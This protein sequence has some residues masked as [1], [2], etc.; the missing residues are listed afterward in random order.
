MTNIGIDV[1]KHQGVID[2]A[3]VKAANIAFAMI[4]AGYGKVSSQKDS[5]FEEN[6]KN[7]KA[8]GIP[9]GAYHYSYAKT[10]EDAKKEAQVF[11][12][13]IAGKQFEYPVVFDIEDASQANLGKQLISDII[14]AFC[15][16]VESAGYYVSVYANKDW[17]L[18]RID[19]DVKKKYDTWLAEWREEPTY[20][21][22]FGIH[23]Y[24]SKGSVS[25]ITG[26]VDMN[27]STK[28]YPGIIKKNGLNGFNKTNNANQNTPQGDTGKT[29]QTFS[30]HTRVILSNSPL[31][32][33]S[34]TMKVAARKTGAYY[35]YDGIE[36][37]G[38]YRITNADSN[39][40]KLPMSNCVTGYVNKN[41]M[42]V[43]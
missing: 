9:V 19:D 14:R 28:D 39:V 43:G 4:R 25:G 15:S 41:D 37:N 35:I 40:G 3:K 2:W 33:S 24:T 30:A 31:Y 8:V 22:N 13:W 10:V 16:A 34:T 38:R 32:A 27:K 42:K 36:M 26:N 7:A 18:N 11:L 20:T 1:S 23:Q 5:K 12:S 6:Y 21:G 17:L 29:T